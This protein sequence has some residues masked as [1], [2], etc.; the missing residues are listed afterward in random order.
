MKFYTAEMVNRW[1]GDILGANKEVYDREWEE[2]QDSYDRHYAKI[3]DNLPVSARKFCEAVLHNE[4]VVAL[5]RS[6]DQE[7]RILGYIR[8][9]DYTVVTVSQRDK[10]LHVVTYSL[11]KPPLAKVN[12]GNG[13]DPPENSAVWLYD[14]LGVD[15][16]G[17][18]THNILFSNGVEITVTFKT[19]HWYEALV[20]ES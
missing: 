9:D 7:G 4:A 12:D 8:G 6:V 5:P 11:E 19:I 1:N 14:E 16:A 2:A 10:T 20:Q 18:F 13:F 3:A 17:M 15:D